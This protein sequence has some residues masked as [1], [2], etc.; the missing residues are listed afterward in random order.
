MGAESHI[1]YLDDFNH[2]KQFI[3]DNFDS[4]SLAKTFAQLNWEIL[5]I[6]SPTLESSPSELSEGQF[7]DDEES[8]MRA[9]VWDDHG[10]TPLPS[11]NTPDLPSH[12]VIGDSDA[13]ANERPPEPGPVISPYPSPSLAPVPQPEITLSSSSTDHDATLPDQ[14]TLAAPARK[15]RSKVGKRGKARAGPVGEDDDAGGRGRNRKAATKRA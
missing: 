3:S 4:P 5:S 7:N 9:E 11:F 12:D 13:Q 6:S 10:T 8:R 2:Y 15:T 1:K 14:D